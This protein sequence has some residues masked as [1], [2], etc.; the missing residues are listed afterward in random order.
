METNATHTTTDA[1]L[2]DER[3]RLLA[4]L[5]AEEGLDD[6]APGEPAIAPRAQRDEAPLTF[7]QEVLWLLDR[8]TP[9]LT[10]YNTPVAR[11]VRGP[12]DVAA[13]ERA[14][15]AL[16]ARHETLRT[17][18]AARG[19]GAVQ[20][21]LP[22]APVTVA[23]HD[24]RA[25]P[26]A[27]REA[28]AIAALRAVTDTPFD[29]AREPG[30]RAAVA[31][32][33]DDEHVV[34]LLTHHIVS[35][36]WSYG[37]L[38]RELN[39][40]VSGEALP[41]VAL[42]FGD[43]AAWQRETLQ[44]ERL[45]ER[46][47]YWRTTLA[48]LPTLEL[49]TDFPGR[50]TPGF[51]GAR[52]GTTL[53]AELSDRVRA[54][55]QRNDATLY[56]VLLAAVQTVLHRYAGQDDVVVGS[57][58][59]GRTRR[60]AESMIGYFSQALPM[61]TRF[62]GDPTFAALLAR[63][64]DTVLGAF[65]H[66]D[67]P[68]ETLVLELQRQQARTAPLFRV[69]L[70]MQDALPVALRLGTSDTEPVE[71]DASATKF[72]LTFL[73]TDTPRGVDIALWYRTELFRAETATR[74]LGHLETVLDAAVA[75]PETRVSALPLLTRAERAQ[76]A[77][78]TPAAAGTTGARDTIVSLFEVQA[79]RV[80]GRVA[81]VAP[82][83]AAQAAGSVAGSVTLTYAEL[84]ARANQLARHL[85]AAGVSAGTPVGLLLDRSAE[86][87]VGLLGI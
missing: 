67:V 51:A 28:A 8:A 85:R 76:L 3:A 34:L 47:A 53:S 38:F 56:M 41:P 19:D 52:V 2:A 14:L 80:P 44:G 49:P 65:E 11:R 63:V 5:L 35:D 81:V 54:F 58:V 10:A 86:A 70:T 23:V 29:L 64:R 48:D 55:A 27:E 1:D 30:F 84:N 6:G 74:L 46:L 83:A 26:A 71:L 9:G 60:E 20:V 57:A 73:V 40:L 43:F 21:V 82:S 7:A 50:G 72:D 59:A 61:R 15:G 31:H 75:S 4:A 79:A 87:M 33:A 77:A 78:W 45:E 25:L 37:V 13:L 22:P 68:V 39:A 32:L 24:V 18:F 69:V 42:Q 62:D 12:L 36:A 66:Q 16:V 17:V